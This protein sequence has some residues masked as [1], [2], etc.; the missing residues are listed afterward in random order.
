MLERITRWSGRRELV[1]LLGLLAIVAGTWLFIELAD[2]VQEGTTQSLDEAII[3]RLRNPDDPTRPIGPAWTGEVARDMTA[4]GGVGV[5]LLITAAVSGYLWLDGRR[6]AMGF[7]LA[8]TFGGVAV[9]M[10]LKASFSRP[11]PDVVPHL[12]DVY[13]SSFPSGH[14]MMSAVVYLTLGA[15]L[16]RLVARRRLKLYFLAVAALLT[17]LVGVSRVFMG[18]HYPTDVLAGWSAGLV[19]ASAC[20]LIARRLQERGVLQERRGPAD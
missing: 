8:A 20:W 15:L 4:L 1:V 13:T 2:E 17:G 6:A 11:R 3:Q 19:W 7:V 18:V 10:L 5:L 12:S 16:T 9:G 14:S